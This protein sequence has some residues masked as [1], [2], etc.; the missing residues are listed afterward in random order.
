MKEIL[1]RYH[2]EI[3][4]FGFV[5]RPYVHISALL[6]ML[7][8]IGLFAYFFKMSLSGFILTLIVY[9][10]TIPI[11]LYLMYEYS[12]EE[13]EFANYTNFL[14]QLLAAFKLHPKILYALKE[15][16]GVTS[17]EL[18]R[19][20]NHSI[21][22]LENGDSYEDSIKLLTNTYHHY[23]LTN[24]FDLMVSVELY[25]ANKYEEGINLIQDDLDDVIEDMY[26]YQKELMQIRSKVF[27]LCL[28]SIVVC[29]MSRN[30]MSNLYNF[31]HTTLY[32]TVLFLYVL[33]LLASVSLSQL[34]LRHTWKIWTNCE[35]NQ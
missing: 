18:L 8:S 5:Y 11:L 21:C 25:G 16:R 31:D 29:F 27:V 20:I 35:V 13:S 9:L 3:I 10:I 15:A 24:A 32:Q 1:T 26:L 23:L 12:Y 28:L 7:T 6:G 14:T 2:K 34:F 4:G 22:C 30:M 17:G 19:L 33:V